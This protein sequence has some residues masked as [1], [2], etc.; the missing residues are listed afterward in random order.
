MSQTQETRLNVAA[1]GRAKGT[2]TIG[3][4]AAPT[5]NSTRSSGYSQALQVADFL[6]TGERNARSMRYL[7]GILHRDGRTIRALIEQERWRGV[8]I[9]SNNQT[10]YYL[11][12]DQGEVMRFVRSMKH[13]AF[14][15]LRTAEIIEGVIRKNE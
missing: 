11:A 4:K 15:I 13:R 6:G 5:T 8:L 10:G 3:T 12:A 7:K 1:P 2:A 14:E 9:L